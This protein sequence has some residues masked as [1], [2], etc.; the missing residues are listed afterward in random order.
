MAE[1][2]ATISVRSRTYHRPRR[3]DVTF[4]PTEKVPTATRASGAGGRPTVD[5]KIDKT[6]C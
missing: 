3:L 5:A 6:F 2:F 1:L 4:G